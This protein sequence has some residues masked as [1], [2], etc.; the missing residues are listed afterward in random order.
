MSLT[1]CIKSHH[2]RSSSYT[3]PLVNWPAHTWWYL[4]FLCFFFC[5]ELYSN[6]CQVC[7]ITVIICLV[8]GFTCFVQ[9]TK[10][11]LYPWSL[12]ICAWLGLVIALLMV[13]LKHALMCIEIVKLINYD[14]LPIL[15]LLYVMLCI[16]LAYLI[17]FAA[18]SN[19]ACLYNACLFFVIDLH[20]YLYKCFFFSC[21]VFCLST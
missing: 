3:M 19:A 18:L 15:V 20:C 6:W 14:C 21:F 5:L 1:C 10:T 12:C 2:T 13:F 11:E 9:F 16:M 7:P 17:L 4:V 8:W